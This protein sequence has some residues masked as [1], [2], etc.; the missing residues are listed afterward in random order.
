MEKEKN[1]CSVT[2]PSP[3]VLVTN[4]SRFPTTRSRSRPKTCFAIVSNNN[5]D[6]L[7][8]VFS[9]FHF[10]PSLST[11][12]F[13]FF[14]NDDYNVLF[15]LVSNQFI[16]INLYSIPSPSFLPP[17]LLSLSLPSS[18][19][20]V[21][22]EDPRITIA[23]GYGTYRVPHTCIGAFFSCYLQSHTRLRRDDSNLIFDI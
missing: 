11:L 14:R 12:F 5:H 21:I 2:L 10:A 3:A 22:P 19:L 4:T 6:G 9:F 18:F 23:Y 1:P 7:F 16:P 13:S 17:L 20:L 8:G 15:L